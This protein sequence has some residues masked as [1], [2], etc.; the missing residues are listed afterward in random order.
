MKRKQSIIIF[1]SL[2]LILVIGY[3]V[4]TV[5]TTHRQG[6]LDQEGGLVV[7]TLRQSSIAAMEYR[8]D[9]ENFDFYIDTAG[10][11]H[12]RPDAE[13]PVN[14]AMMSNMTALLSKVT[15]TRE[16]SGSEVNLEEFGLIN[17]T[18]R[19]VITDKGD[20]K[21]VY[22]V[23]VLNDF[24]NEYYFMLG[25]SDKVYT[26]GPELA[27]EFSRKLV[28]LALTDT[29]PVIDKDSYKSLAVKSGDKTAEFKYLRDPADFFYT[30]MYN[31]FIVNPYDFAA[32][33][34]AKMNSLLSTA[35]SGL[36]MVACADYKPSLEA[37]ESYGLVSP[38]S[39]VR[40]DYTV[41]KTLGTSASGAVGG[42]VVE[43]VYYRLLIGAER[44]EEY[45]YVLIEGSDTVG[46]VL[47]QSIAPLIGFDAHNY[48]P[49]EVMLMDFN[50]VDSM[51]IVLD[52]KTYAV[53]KEKA[54]VGDVEGQE[55]FKTTY[56]I[57][58][59]EGDAYY[60]EEFLKTIRLLT[61]ESLA[62]KEVNE[63]PV[64]IVT[65]NRNT[66]NFKKMTIEFTPYDL[67]F[68]LVEFNGRREQLV[69]KRDVEKIIDLFG[70]AMQK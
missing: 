24:T 23:G 35:T 32:A 20:Q 31:W 66:N 15:A 11:W 51:D 62:S 50:T 40:I 53:K 5:V 21:T 46:L 63:R 26:I 37:L 36:E 41:T 60:I 43:D 52:G 27:D 16:I 17:P 65:F 61:S 1:I 47:S 14:P 39:D 67:N 3:I 49:V 44:D 56:T 55:N 57:N 19:I 68:Y 42:T 29:P 7:S 10:K 48:L 70:S 25:E 45:T 6:F 33:G 9:G 2:L 59:A 13:F 8:I 22:N 30:D 64:L 69:N 34:T 58:G 12:F 38:R 4:I 28:E 18:L 54:K